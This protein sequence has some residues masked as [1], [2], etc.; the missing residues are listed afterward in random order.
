MLKSKK[1][2]TKIINKN[3]FIFKLLKIRFKKQ[4]TK[5]AQIP[6]AIIV[7]VSNIPNNLW[8]KL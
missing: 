5:S 3:I 8:L 2:K 7:E 4:N 6:F 1:G